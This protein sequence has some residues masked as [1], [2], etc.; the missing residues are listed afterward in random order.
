MSRR[1]MSRR[2]ETP[3]IHRWSRLLIAAIAA[4][5]A[6]GTAYLTMVKFIGGTAA[7]P[8]SGCDRVLASDYATLFGLPL[9]VFGFLAYA[10][11]AILAA[12][13]LAINPEQNKELRQKLESWTWLLLF[14]GSLSMVVFSGYLMYV[15]TAEIKAACL[16][17]I[18]SALFT[19]SMLGLTLLGHRWEDVGQLLFV[20]VIALV[21]VL[22]GTLAI[23]A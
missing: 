11:M 2:R 9:T 22:T 13:P 19:V 14:I 5:G 18:A 7:C 23:Y 16:Y 6:A 8:T 15:L 10:G 21:V 20:G 4:I 1:L 12:G 17:C 3:W